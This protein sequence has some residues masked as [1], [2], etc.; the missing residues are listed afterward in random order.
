MI[1]Y[2]PFLFFLAFFDFESE[3][4]SSGWVWVGKI[5]LIEIE[6]SAILV[7]LHSPNK[8]E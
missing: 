2:L 6:L 1:I 3:H 5:K 8:P 4:N 7:R